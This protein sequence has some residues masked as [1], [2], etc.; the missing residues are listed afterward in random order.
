MINKKAVF[1]SVMIGLFITA[2][3][4]KDSDPLYSCDGVLYDRPLANIRAC[5]VGTWQLHY[6]KGGLTGNWR[7]DFTNIS[8]TI[9]PDDSVYYVDNDVQKAETIITWEGTT[10]IQGHSTYAITFKDNVG[11]PFFWVVEA[12]LQDTLY[13]SDNI[14]D[15]WGYALTKTKK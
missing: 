7:E 6:R 12:N 8:L 1:L 3:G 13:L 2:Y 14:V 10:T 15:G 5:V 4:C 11:S 9:L